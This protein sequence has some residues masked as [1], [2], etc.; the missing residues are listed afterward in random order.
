MLRFARI[1][2][3]A[4]FLATALTTA[5]SGDESPATPSPKDYHHPAVAL[6]NLQHAHGP[7]RSPF[8]LQDELDG[9]I[10]EGGGGACASAAAIDAL[11][12]LRVMAG[13]DPL[14]N[15]HK[16]VLKAFRDNKALLKGRV[17]NEQ[18]VGLIEFYQP[19]LGGARVRVGVE[20]TTRHFI[21]GVAALQRAERD[22]V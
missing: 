13:L 15:P 19:F 5:A 7:D 17:S 3:P 22:V 21:R 2:L 11:Q 18:F 12:T 14:A 10:R 4:L 6:G 16:A 8:V 9:L 20:Q 1:I